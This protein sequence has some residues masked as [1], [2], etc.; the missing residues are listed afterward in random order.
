MAVAIRESVTE[1][2]GVLVSATDV[3]NTGNA[4]VTGNTS[5]LIYLVDIDNTNN[6]TDVYLKI[7][8][9]GSSVGSGQTPDWMLKGK[10]GVIT[11]YVFTSG[12]PYS[13][14]VSIWC[15]LSATVNDTNSPASSV[16]VDIVAS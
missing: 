9:H 2:G 16:R 11:S 8:D 13:A 10:S 3:S 15:T 6:T 5:G 14:G 12:V 4:N 1:L 7:K